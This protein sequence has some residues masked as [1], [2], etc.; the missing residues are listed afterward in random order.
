MLSP[1]A[2]GSADGT[3]G[4]GAVQALPRCP[5]GIASIARLPRN[6]FPARRLADLGDRVFSVAPDTA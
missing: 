5:L 6:G 2:E 1:F 4:S 3:E